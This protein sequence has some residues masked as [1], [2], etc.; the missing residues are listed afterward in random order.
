MEG[1][2]KNIAIVQTNSATAQQSAA[3]SEELSS[4][5]NLLKSMIEYFTLEDDIANQNTQI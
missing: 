1:K 5:A 4:Q 3:A 2:I